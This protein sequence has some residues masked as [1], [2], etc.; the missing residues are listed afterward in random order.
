MDS[1]MQAGGLMIEGLVAG[2]GGGVVLDNLSLA[3]AGGESVALLGRNGVGKTTLLRT[4]M[5][6][7]QPKRGTIRFAGMRIDN[8]EPFEIARAG[9][10]YVPQGREIFQELT[11]EENLRLGSYMRKDKDGVKRSLETAYNLFPIL[12]QRRK[13][14]AG[15]L[16]GGEQQMLALARGLMLKPRVLLLDEPSFGLAPCSFDTTRARTSAGMGAGLVAGLTGL[17]CAASRELGSNPPNASV[18]A[19]SRAAWAM[20]RMRKVRRVRPGNPCRVGQPARAQVQ[21][22]RNGR[23]NTSRRARPAGT[24]FSRRKQAQPRG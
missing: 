14:Q 3:V 9:L 17:S 6:L 10:G 2:Y 7:N 15:T 12:E 24:R 19:A 16:S 1:G 22:P 13:Q 4:I 11:V 8:R 21:P 18:A 5:G 20:I 23:T